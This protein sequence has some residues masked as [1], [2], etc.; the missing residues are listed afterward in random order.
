MAAF[1]WIEGAGKVVADGNRLEAVAYGPP[2]GKA[3]AVACRHSPQTDQ[4]RATLDATI[5]F[6]I[7]MGLERAW[8]EARN[9]RRHM[10]T[11]AVA[12]RAEATRYGPIF[13][14]ALPIIR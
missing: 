11:E 12:S 1:R 6:S 7:E 10:R 3:P 8:F 9:A 14:G 4:P 2:P 13:Q 5:R